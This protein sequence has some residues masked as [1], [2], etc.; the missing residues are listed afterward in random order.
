MATLL[1]FYQTVKEIKEIA[2][3]VLTARD[4]PDLVNQIRDLD[5]EAVFLHSVDKILKQEKVFFIEK[6]INLEY[7][8]DVF[9]KKLRKQGLNFE[10]LAANPK[11]LNIQIGNQIET[12][13]LSNDF[14]TGV[15]IGVEVNAGWAKR[16]TDAV[17]ELY[18]NT[19]FEKLFSTAIRQELQYI[20]NNVKENSK[21][22]EGVN[23]LLDLFQNFVSQTT[24]DYTVLNLKT[25]QELFGVSASLIEFEKIKP[26]TQERLERFYKGERLWWDVITADGDVERDL[27]KATIKN[28]ELYPDSLKMLCIVG[29]SG[30][31]KSTF[32]WRVAFNISRSLNLPVIHLRN[33]ESEEFW[34]LLENG[35]KQYGKPIIVLADDIFRDINSLRALETINPDT[36]VIIISTA[37]SNELP[38]DLSLH[39][40][41]DYI[42]LPPPT[43][44]EITKALDK[45]NIQEELSKKISKDSTWLVLMY[46][47]TTGQELSKHIRDTV[48]RLRDQD[49]IVYRAY[50]YICFT[51]QYDIEFPT[52]LLERMDNDGHF[53][54]IYKRTAANGL[55]F[56]SLESQAYLNASHALIAKF[57]ISAYKR[58]PQKIAD[59]IFKL[60]NYEKYIERSFLVKFILALINHKSIKFAKELLKRLDKEKLHI[61][62]LC[63]EL[64][65]GWEN[66]YQK[67]GET[68]NALAVKEIPSV[69]GTPQRRARPDGA[70][71]RGSHLAAD[72]RALLAPRAAHRAPEAA[73][74][75]AGPARGGSACAVAQRR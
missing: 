17:I 19:L 50:E 28:Y 72:G 47:L 29:E 6:E 18:A 13:I 3:V 42:H 40:N 66:I 39:I 71:D 43:G 70:A 60:I 58:D 49:A 30:A 25:A 64:I 52:K 26:A 51:G 9:K 23:Q 48:K 53:F 14:L 32:A 73:S 68:T 57:A 62:S 20:S 44:E 4:I 46:E 69:V 38:D 45:L 22:L 34:Y 63:S 65:S 24:S 75:P 35:I 10:Q 15:D 12:W 33:N 16:V 8:L 59:D 21:I 11:T 5:S 56:Q 31:G 2:E 27:Q 1:Q 61:H 37:R 67:L 74:Q 36:S 41:I 55:I 7:N 54:E